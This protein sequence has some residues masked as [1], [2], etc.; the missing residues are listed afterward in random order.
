MHKRSSRTIAFSDQPNDT[1]TDSSSDSDSD[2]STDSDNSNYNTQ[3]LHWSPQIKRARYITVAPTVPI[4]TFTINDDIEHFLDDIQCYL[5]DYPHLPEHRKITIVRSAIKGPAR[6]ILRGYTA[7]ETTTLKQLYH[8][9]KKEFK[10]KEKCARSLY[11]IKQEELEPVNL[12]VGRI[13]RYVTG[14]KI[15]DK[16]ARDNA[17][18]EFFKMGAHN[19]IQN[20]LHNIRKFSRAIKIAT[21]VEGEKSKNKTTKEAVNTMDSTTSTSHGANNLKNEI[22]RLCTVIQQ[23]S[24]LLQSQKGMQYRSSEEPTYRTLRDSKL[25]GTKNSYEL[26]GRCF[27]CSKRGHRFRQCRQASDKDKEYIEKRL[28]EQHQDNRERKVVNINAES[29]NSR[30]ASQR[31]TAM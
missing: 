1:H 26:K 30:V 24:R 25:A 3:D 19:Y 28:T 31:P 17:C 29:L 12:F 14:L 22:E 27:H 13:R 8:I 4:P 15:T 11:K 20:R 9:L 21:E 18:L 23:Q 16:H 7:N 5:E 6:D 10:K 2:D